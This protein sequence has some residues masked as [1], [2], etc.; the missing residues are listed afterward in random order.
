VAK[1]RETLAVSKQTMHRFCIEKFS[2]SRLNKVEGKEHYCVKKISNR[3]T[4]LEN[5]DDEEDINRAGLT[6][7]ENVKISA[8]ESQ[9]YYELKHKP[10]FDE[11]GSELLEQNK[12]G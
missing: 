9:G 8:K 7:R 5:T 10:Q 11:G 3:F 2:L 4:A 1:V 12:W 6:I